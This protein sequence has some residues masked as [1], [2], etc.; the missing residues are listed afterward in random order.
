MSDQ[1]NNVDPLILDFLEQEQ[2]ALHPNWAIIFPESIENSKNY[3]VTISGYFNSPI[4]C[5]HLPYPF[6][7]VPFLLKIHSKENPNPT[8]QLFH[9]IHFSSTNISDLPN[10]VDSKKWYVGK[11]SRSQ[12]F[13][14]K[15]F[16]D[17]FQINNIS[18]WLNEVYKNIFPQDRLP[19]VPSNYYIALKMWDDIRSLLLLLPKDVEEIYIDETNIF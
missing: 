6:L 5:P 11:N 7:N 9:N 16:T 12:I 18:G 3:P 17:K 4:T 10:W 14:A 19:S 1:T 13:I 8:L 15:S 2:K